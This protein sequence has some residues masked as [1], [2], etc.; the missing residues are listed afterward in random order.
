MKAT[1]IIPNYNGIKFLPDCIESLQRLRHEAYTIQKC[2]YGMC[3]DGTDRGIYK[4]NRES[5]QKD[6]KQT[7]LQVRHRESEKSRK[8]GGAAGCDADFEILVVDNGSTDGSAEWLREHQIP[9][10]ELTENL[11]F[12]G[13]VNRGIQACDSEYVILL[14]NDTIVQDGFVR[15]LI[16]A[17]ESSER[18]FAVGAMMLRSDDHSRIDS[19]GDGLTV[20]GWAYQ[21]GIDEDMTDYLSE[22][23]VFAACAGAAIYRRRIFDEIGLFDEMHFA[24]LE[25]IDICYR[26]RLA[27]YFSRY[28]PTARVYHLGSATSG[29]KYNSFKVRLSARNN[30]YLMYKNQPDW[31]LLINAPAMAAGCII[32]AAFFLKKG[33]FKDYIGGLREGLETVRK[34]TRAP[35]ARYGLLTYAAVQWE[36]IMDTFE[37]CKAYLR[38]N[39][40]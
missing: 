8:H 22:C 12:A 19:A 27:G 11:G 16:R 32:K 31:Q 24:Y 10:L 29:S 4:Q 5:G 33:F 3:A 14:N 9:T 39:I 2:E 23:D 26:A 34:C 15:E 1:V 35:R 25:D 28:C 7:Q 13:G 6:K 20:L 37:Y 30:V 17:I 36:L 18:L 38:R 40:I 21:R